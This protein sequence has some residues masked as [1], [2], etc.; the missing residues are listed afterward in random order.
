MSSNLN[1]KLLFSNLSYKTTEQTLMNYFSTYGSLEELHLYKDDQD[2]SLRKGFIIYKE[3]NSMNNLMLKRPHFIDN[4]QIHIQRAIPNQCR[5]TTNISEYLGINLTV[6]EIFISRLCSGEKREMFINY[7]QSYGNIIDC[8]VINSYSQNSKQTGYAFVRFADYDSIDQIIL[9]RPHVINSK[10]YHVRKCIP[11]EYNYII[12]SIKPLSQNK[13][14]WRHFS[15]GLINMKTH[16]I[17]YP[18]VPTFRKQESPS[19]D[20]TIID[21]PIVT[22]AI[23]RTPTNKKS[24]ND[25]ELIA[26]KSLSSSSISLVNST[27]D[28]FTPLASPLYSTAIAYSSPTTIDNE[29]RKIYDLI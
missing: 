10:F 18:S 29:D 21:S 23:D 2:Q 6:H 11:R 15:F 16:E 3:I 19:N 8:R 1:K 22:V 13:P 5:N 14:M 7:F 20:F 25:F 27:T 17:I 4:R 9:S 26:S 24:T 12:S 28:D